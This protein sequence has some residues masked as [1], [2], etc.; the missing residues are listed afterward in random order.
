MIEGGQ[1]CRDR[2][3][4]YPMSRQSHEAIKSSPKNVRLNTPPLMPILTANANGLP[5][6]TVPNTPPVAAPSAAVSVRFLRHSIIPF[7]QVGHAD[8]WQDGSLASH[9]RDKPTGR[10]DG[11]CHEKR[12][13]RVDRIAHFVGWMFRRLR[14]VTGGAHV[15]ARIVTRS[16]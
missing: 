15:L 11:L 16:L 13:I 3:H 4:P 10:D 1:I 9:E 8:L 6:R 2:A 12:R 7:N 5:A 14:E